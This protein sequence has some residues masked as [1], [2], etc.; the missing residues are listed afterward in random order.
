MEMARGYLESKRL[1]LHSAC[2]PPQSRC[3]RPFDDA[4]N[5]RLA[6]GLANGNAHRR[7]H[8]DLQNG[9]RLYRIATGFAR[10]VPLAPL[11][12]R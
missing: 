3:R 9:L 1:T 4:V 10:R 2:G 12:N 6:P 8:I 7:E 11:V 5:R